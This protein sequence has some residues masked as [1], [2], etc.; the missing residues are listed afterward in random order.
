MTMERLVYFYLGTLLLLN[1]E[2]AS[3][4]EETSASHPFQTDPYT[5]ALFHFDKAE[6]TI[7]DNLVKE[8]PNGHLHNSAVWEPIDHPGENKRFGQALLLI[9]QNSS[10]TWSDSP[11]GDLPG[12]YTVEFWIRPANLASGAI[13]GQTFP[14]NPSHQ[15]MS[16]VTYADKGR[17]VH[18]NA[19]GPGDAGIGRTAWVTTIL[20]VL[21]VGQWTHVAVVN[22]VPHHRL[23][24]F[25]DNV[26]VPV[27]RADH[28]HDRDAD[29]HDPKDITGDFA[30][31][32]GMFENQAASFIGVLDEL[33]ISNIARY[34]QSRPLAISKKRVLFL[35]ELYV[36]KKEN[37]ER[38][39][40]PPRKHPNNPIFPRKKP[41]EKY[42]TGLG[43]VVFDSQAGLFKCWYRG[44]A[45]TSS[46]MYS[47]EGSRMYHCYATSQDGLQ[48]ERPNLSRVEFEGSKENNILPMAYH[49]FPIRHGAE[50]DK[51]FAGLQGR[52]GENLF[53][54]DNGLD[55]E[56]YP[57]NP[58]AGGVSFGMSGIVY[59]PG[60]QLYAAYGQGW[61]RLPRPGEPNRG[62]RIIIGRFS[63]DLTS[64]TIP[65]PVLVP[66]P[67]DPPGL[68]FY[69]MGCFL[70][71]DMYIGLPWT[72]YSSYGEGNEPP[73]PR[74]YG[75]INT[76]LVVSRD[77]VH[78]SRV[79][80]RVP[81]IPLGQEGEWDDGMV[82]GLRPMRM[83]DE[84]YFYYSGYDGHHG[85]KDR[86][87]AGGLAILPRDRYLSV[88]PGPVGDSGRLTTIRLKPA[89]GKLWVNADASAGEIRVALLSEEGQPL[90]GYTSDECEPITTDTLEHTVRW[91][92]RS[93]LP[94][95]RRF[96]IEF[97]L[98]GAV[99]LFGFGARG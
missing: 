63:K 23:E 46:K 62:S 25:I 12:T 8:E 80:A 83:G 20:P 36:D 61:S 31:G 99:H 41:W 58:V 43:N 37:L 91:K 82:F 96:R 38:I 78:W 53:Y 42:A 4:T 33:R 6:G 54:S 74:Q 15:R 85:G 98:D 88:T 75:K 55:W 35:D 47:D 13:V 17:I 49:V 50:A 64:W 39:L 51:Q 81:F 14:R 94:G 45:S 30:I 86:V 24:I 57:E 5:V 44:I 60:R 27:T 16:H 72:Y 34:P 95:G 89:S 69:A 29:P 56:P 65:T 71:G 79:A 76:E 21:R 11:K 67:D 2:F 1:P 48:W 93:R 84:I 26:S 22:N 73:H 66:L 68:E 52:G 92:H 28:G 3:G 59:D 40:N 18:R 9:D 77:G 32:A 90:A 10:M 7:I 70:D 97:T 87:S 19:A